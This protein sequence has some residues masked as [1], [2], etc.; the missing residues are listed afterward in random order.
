[1]AERIETTT[2]TTPGEGGIDLTLLEYCLSLSP[3]ERLRQVEDYAE[4]V[5][6]ARSRNGVRWSDTE[7]S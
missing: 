4:F 1:M 2:P 3:V 7:R 6:T 5:L